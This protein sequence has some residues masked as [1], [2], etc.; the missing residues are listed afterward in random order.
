MRWTSRVAF[1]ALLSLAVAGPAHAAGAP[2][3]AYDLTVK[4]SGLEDLAA[5]G[6]DVTEGV[7]GNHV[8]VAATPRQ[9]RRLI[10]LGFR[11]Q[12]RATRGGG[13]V[14]PDYGPSGGYRVWRPYARQAYNLNGDEVPNLIDEMKQ[15]AA[16]NP[17]IVKLEK[18][19]ETAGGPD[20]PA[21]EDDDDY[22][23]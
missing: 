8:T 18:I 10:K 17:G 11:P 15:L 4:P 9:A 21:T 1:A 23:E 6:F 19:G 20:D 16:D 22:T 12:L 2:L 3:R 13:R 7:K 5:A 14:A